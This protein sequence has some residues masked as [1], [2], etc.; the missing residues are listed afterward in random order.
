MRMLD[1]SRLLLV[2]L[3]LSGCASYSKLDVTSSPINDV[4]IKVSKRDILGRHDGTTAFQ[5][6]YKSDSE[7]TLTAPSKVGEYDFQGWDYMSKL[8]PGYACTTPDIQV[9]CGD[10]E[11]T[12]Y[13]AILPAPTPGPTPDPTPPPQPDPALPVPIKLAHSGPESLPDGLKC[14]EKDSMCQAYGISDVRFLSVT[15]DSFIR[16]SMAKPHVRE[17]A[18]MLVGDDFEEVCD[19]NHYVFAWDHWSIGTSAN[20]STENPLPREKAR[21]T[22]RPW[23]RCYR[24]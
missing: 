9:S 19:G 12:A 1:C 16:S 24:E 23:W 20:K 2:C 6:I 14:K 17:V 7:V 3:L 22:F 18:G 5:R 8:G 11:I 4:P 21:A 10:E 13:Y 15:G